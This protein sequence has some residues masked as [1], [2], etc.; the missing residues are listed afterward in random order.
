MLY[1]IYLDEYFVDEK[2]ITVAAVLS[3]Q[4]TSVQCAEFDA[5]EP[6]GLST[7]GDSSLRE[8]IFDITVA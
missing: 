2:G 7:N 1:A 3:L 6:D 8:E 5:P 4:S